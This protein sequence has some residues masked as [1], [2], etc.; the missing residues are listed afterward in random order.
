MLIDHSSLLNRLC[1]PLTRQ[2][3]HLV[4]SCP[5][6]QADI[7]SGPYLVTS[8][9]AH[10]YPVIDNIPRFVPK[11][12]YA[13]NFGFQWNYFAKTQLDSVSGFPISASRFWSATGW[14]TAELAGKWVLDAGC[15]SGRFAEIALLAGAYVVAFDYSSSVDACYNNLSHFPNFFVLQADIYSLPFVENS[16]DYIYSL[17]VLQ[18]TPDVSKAFSNLP[19]L[20]SKNSGKI[21]VDFYWNRPLTTLQPK[22]F[23]RHFSRFLSDNQLFALI[24]F[25]L[26]YLLPL[27]NFLAG[28]PLF[29]PFLRRLVPI[30][31]YTGIYPL[32]PQQI[33]E[34]ALLDT[35]DMFSP[36]YDN[37]QTPASITKMFR[38][39]H[40]PDPYIFHS[41]LLV[42]RASL[43][44]S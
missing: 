42:A 39:S 17:G 32:S 9:L 7:P 28:I 20:L 22:Y 11:G 40:L 30:A 23:L 38:S 41:T 2:P 24:K 13:D 35:F 12:N 44:S 21:C 8:D 4:E 15:G 36:K 33:R 37:P 26:P 31:N 25:L 18:H 16:F 1:C 3:L 29:G 27:S 14:T 10:S 6:N 5:D 19:P 43:H 34:W